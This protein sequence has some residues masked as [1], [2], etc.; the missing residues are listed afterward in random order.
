MM[1][2]EEPLFNTLRS[3]EQLG[4]DVSCGLRD[5]FGILGYS[6]MVNSQENKFSS[7]YV[8]ERI[9]NFRSSQLFN[10]IRQTTDGEFQQ[11]KESLTKIKLN[12]DNSMKDEV[13]RHWAE[14][15]TNEYA[16]DRAFRDVECLNTITKSAFLKFFENH[17]HN[18]RKLSI[19][20][21]YRQ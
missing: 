1:V 2:S 18:T 15:I 14:I 4:Y 16:F 3:K 5:N 10:I 11:Y 8:E 12:D 9:E 7:E 6:I 17:F 21:S 19:Q 13:S 20:V